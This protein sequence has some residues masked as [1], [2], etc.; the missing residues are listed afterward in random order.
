MMFV[1]F[2][3][4]RLFAL[5]CKWSFAAVYLVLG[6]FLCGVVAAAPGQLDPT[7]GASGV[8]HPIDLGSG[9]FYSEQANALL[10][11]PSGSWVVGHSCYLGAP[12]DNH[13]AMCLKRFT[14]A[15]QL[16]TSF[17]VAGQAVAD[18][19]T[20]S[21]S[22]PYMTTIALFLALQADG[23]ILAATGC[24][25]GPFPGGF[26]MARLLADGTLDPSFNSAG[27][28]PGTLILPYNTLSDFSARQIALQA[29]GKIILAGQ[30]SYPGTMCVTRLTASGAIDTTFANAA[31]GTA[32]AMPFGPTD[33]RR[34]TAILNRVIID[35]D[36]RI[37]V[38]GTCT[39]VYV[40]STYTCVGRLNPNG[41]TDPTFANADT[42][43]PYYGSWFGIPTFGYNATGNHV[44]VQ[45]DSKIVFIGD[46]GDAPATGTCLVRLLNTGAPDPGFTNAASGRAGIVR[47]DAPDGFKASRA[48]NIQ[49]DGKIVFAG[50]CS[51]IFSLF[52]VGRLNPD[53]SLDTTFDES[54]GNGNGIVQ[55]AIGPG[56]GYATDVSVA[57]TGKILLSGSC[58]LN[59]G[60]RTGCAAR[61]LGGARD[62][63]ACT[64]NADANN[65]IDSS[66]DA[67]LIV[68]YLL[69]YR[70]SALTD[71]ALGTNP[72][73]TGTALENHL[74]S[75]N[76]D[77][78]GDGQAHAM[79]DGLLILR[80]MLGLTGIALI[81]GATNAGHPNVRN[82]QQVLTW[83]E[84]TH[85]VACLP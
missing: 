1:V 54:P 20:S 7:F 28:K 66:T 85:G 64:L 13:S 16:D 44:A 19:P 77:A 22:N 75:L 38:V 71:G 83:I 11:L 51:S 36:D 57:A 60:T 3:C 78:D 32:R 29:N 62:V 35:S 63:S 37:N 5:S 25:E 30:C 23:K 33:V 81:Q 39:T 70:G 72:T 58:R 12:A 67:V 69:G 79:T 2:Q 45:A 14:A 65:A 50:E 8:V 68:R 34:I 43:V 53:G 41:S 17:G 24:A 49:G 52:C 48:V 76:L 40:N 46:C 59:N 80:A 82:A 9:S 21:T 4:S 15:G 56:A 27:S 42:S 26:C 74:A 10:I 47:L 18:F 55:H 61:L 6:G 73:R 31:S 84:S